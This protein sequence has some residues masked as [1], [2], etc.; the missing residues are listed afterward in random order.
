MAYEGSLSEETVIP[1]FLSIVIIN[2]ASAPICAIFIFIRTIL[3]YSQHRRDSDRTGG[4]NQ[5]ATN[6]K[7]ELFCNKSL[8]F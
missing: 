3:P 1:R 7:L 6:L 8:L 2:Y 5:S 4:F